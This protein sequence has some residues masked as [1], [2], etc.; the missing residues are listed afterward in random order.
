MPQGSSDAC[1]SSLSHVAAAADISCLHSLPPRVVFVGRL[2]ASILSSI[3]AEFNRSL[4]SSPAFA[5]QFKASFIVY[6]RLLTNH[7]RRR[8]DKVLN[9]LRHKP[10]IRQA[11]I[12][13]DIYTV[14]DG[15]VCLLPQ[16]TARQY[17]LHFANR[18]SGSSYSSFSSSVLWTISEARVSTM[19]A[20]SCGHEAGA[21]H[22]TLHNHTHTAEHS[23]AK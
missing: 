22:G 11:N 7:N 12:H 21:H 20:T 23:T 4:L 13:T 8:P 15:H 14:H 10:L 2:I 1:R 19:A 17:T 5:G 9:V 16:E 3:A 6:V 18:G